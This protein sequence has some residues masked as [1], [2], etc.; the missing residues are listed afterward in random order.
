M[1]TFGRAAGG[2]WRPPSAG[3]DNARMDAPWL[4]LTMR[5]ALCAALGAAAAWWIGPWALAL[6]VPAAGALLAR[7]LLESAAVLQ[8]ALRARAIG[9]LE[10]RQMAYRGHAL[11]VIED[12]AGRRWIA[13]DD[14]R[15]IV[16]GLPA[17]AVLT[18]IAPGTVSSA[19]GGR[20]ARLEAEALAV[21]LARATD[22]DTHRFVRWVDREIVQPARRARGAPIGSPLGS[23]LGSPSRDVGRS[24]PPGA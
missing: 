18:R 6:V 17:P 10:G 9:D 13:L 5:L 19:G 20:R 2:W 3:R 1:T 16:P 23:P 22:A 12:D 15:R 7:P 21:V 4:Q 14:L 11:D 8:R 24:P